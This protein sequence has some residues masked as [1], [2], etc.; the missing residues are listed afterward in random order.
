MNGRGLIL[1][2]HAVDEGPPPLFVSPRLFREHVGC[3]IASGAEVLSLDQV[4]DGL[5][6]GGLPARWVAL[7]FDDGYRSVVRH[8]A[9]ILA[10]HSLPAT[11]F[12][13]AGRLGGDNAWPGQPAAVPRRPLATAAE[14]AELPADAWAIGSHGFDHVSLDDASEKT[15]MREVVDSRARLE[16]EVG[17]PVDWF[18]PPHGISPAGRPAALLA[19]TY[20]GC[21][22]LGTRPAGPGDS[23]HALPRVDAHYLRRPALLRRALAGRYDHLTLRRIGATLRPGAGRQ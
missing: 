3:I 12:C 7:T 14:L 15:T 18:A 21:C 8:A 13:L 2:Y 1:A 5:E 19:S 22:A 10:E 6:S 23:R 9:P 16:A 20:R 11:A 4:A 17:T